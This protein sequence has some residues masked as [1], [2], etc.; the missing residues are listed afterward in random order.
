MKSEK[1]NLIL[2][3]LDK[4]FESIQK[5]ATVMSVP[6]NGW[7]NT[8]RK[9]LNM[10]LKQLAKKLKVTSQ[11]VNQLEVREKDGTISLQK[12]KETAEALDCM[13]VYAIIPKSGSLKK[14]I[15]LRAYNVA[16]EI[17]L[18]TSHTMKL[19]DQ[20]NSEVRIKKAV[21]DRTEKIKNELPKYLWD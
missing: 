16:K 13:L 8:I 19:E 18:R 6:S 9:S 3:Q 17:V 7:L 10:S 11:N 4:K 1:H 14:M 21:S 5:V 2:E 20:E 12:L 15:E